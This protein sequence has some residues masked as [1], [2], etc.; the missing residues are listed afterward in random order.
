MEIPAAGRKRKNSLI[1]RQN[2]TFWQAVLCPVAVLAMLCPARSSRADD[3][4]LATQIQALQR[5]NAIL[6]QKL[7]QQNQSI[8]SLSEKIQDLES[9]PNSTQSQ[10][11]ADNTS[12]APLS[13][14]NL[15]NV[16]I[17]GEGGIALF[18]TGRNGFA[19]DT[20]FRLDEAR[21]F[22]E[23]PVWKSVYFSGE[24]DLATRDEFDLHVSPG[25][26]YLDFQDISDLWGRDGQLNLRAGN[27]YVPFGEEY[28]NRYAIDNP[29]VSHSLSDLWGY[30]PG[31]ELYGG[32]GPFTYVAAV[33]D[34]IFGDG[35][36]GLDGD[37]SV[38][39][40]IGY[41]LNRHFHFSVSGMRTGSVH[42]S[43]TSAIWFGSS[44]FQSVGGP[45]TGWFHTDLVQGDIKASWSSSYVSAF[46][47][48]GHYGDNDPA[49]N[50]GRD[51]FYY[52]VEGMQNLPKNFYVATRFS[53]VLCDK[54]IP[55]QGFGSRTGYYEALAR[56][57]W[58]LS[59]GAGYR[60][61]PNLTV[62][63]EYA[64][65]DGQDIDNLSRNHEN[66]FGT[67]AAF[68]F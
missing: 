52:A 47:G 6:E 45:A 13:G 68:R 10:S 38:A 35:V 7:E 2:S 64:F 36:S 22:V 25:E 3:T 56:E 62:K 1:L 41:D 24:L 58:R 44:F 16:H 55:V 42:A 27:I 32:L 53:Q 31:V 34:P 19:P 48:F 11:P 15:G 29:L 8:Q 57:L 46:G 59:L 60:F 39:G 23:A 50:N 12:P 43:K 5:Q 66:F 26:V 28:L 54:G 51:F 17:G 40:R 33:Q 4:N 61:S 65:E 14:Y 18:N 30:S 63:V 9:N 37:K 20:Q 67:E 21:L 49:A